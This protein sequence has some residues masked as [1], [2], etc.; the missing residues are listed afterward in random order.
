MTAVRVVVGDIT[1]LDEQGEPVDVIVNAANE[2]LAAG[3]GV[4]G[5][6]FAAAGPVRL[7]EACA[8]IGGCP[9]G[10]A[11]DTPAFALEARG[12]GHIVHAVGPVFRAHDP[13][14]SDRLLTSAY[15]SVLATVDDLGAERVAIPAISTGVYG[16]P[17]ERAAAIAAAVVMGH[18]GPVREVLLV[19]FDDRAAAVLQGAVDRAG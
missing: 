8:E 5:A 15:R 13:T 9:T 17:E 2:Q 14:E 16:F 19:A 4:C 3:S 12:V 6:I 7:A 11:V 18:E 1:R 10:A